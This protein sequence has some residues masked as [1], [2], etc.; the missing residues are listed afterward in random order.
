[1]SYTIRVLC[2]ECGR[3][4]TYQSDAESRDCPACGG[5]DRRSGVDERVRRAAAALPQNDESGVLIVDSLDDALALTESVL[6]ASGYP[7][8]LERALDALRPFAEYAAKM[9]RG[10]P[11]SVAIAT[12]QDNVNGDTSITRAD[13]LRAAA[14]LDDLTAETEEA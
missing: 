6:A 4:Y 8:D 7:S 11:E 5:H 3:T 12:L 14:V 1:M 10:L 13:V 9:M 2:K